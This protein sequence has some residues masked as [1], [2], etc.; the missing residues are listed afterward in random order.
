[1]KKITNYTG[2]GFEV[3]LA[4]GKSIYL[5]RSESA[6]VSDDVDDG[7]EE[8]GHDAPRFCDRGSRVARPGDLRACRQKFEQKREESAL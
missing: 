6:I 2:R 1:M 8:A 4:D 7:K 3:I 5:G